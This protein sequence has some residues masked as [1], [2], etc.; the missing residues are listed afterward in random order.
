MP[1]LGRNRTVRFGAAGSK[2]QTYNV[3]ICAC[4]GGAYT[5]QRLLRSVKLSNVDVTPWSAER[6]DGSPSQSSTQSQPISET[7]KPGGLTE[8]LTGLAPVRCYSPA[9][10]CT[11]P[12]RQN[13]L[14]DGDMA[15]G[16]DRG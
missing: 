16:P 4:V 10:Q 14:L 13:T 1:G 9:A 11:N 15:T 3:G 12:M 2:K 6:T 5:A 8:P 7:L